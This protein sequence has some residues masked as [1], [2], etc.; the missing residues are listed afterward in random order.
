MCGHWSICSVS[1]MLSWCFDRFYLKHLKLTKENLK[2]SPSVCR[3]ALCWSPPF[4][5]IQ[6]LYGSAFVLTFCLYGARRPQMWKPSL[7]RP[8]LS[9]YPGLGHV[10]DFL[11]S[12][13][14]AEAFKSSYS[15]I[16]LFSQPFL[17]LASW[18]FHC[19]SQLSFYAPA[20]AANTCTFKCFR[21]K[22]P[23]NLS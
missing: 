8:F 1:L 9:M 12:L 17:P 13:V 14:F 21:Q 23:R 15:H 10:H 5:L 22:P 7:L 2:N 20:F 16:Y 3:F 18:S 11:N 19:L 6:A 4:T